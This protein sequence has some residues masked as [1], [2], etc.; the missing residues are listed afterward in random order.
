VLTP[1]PSVGPP[2]VVRI[3]LTGNPAMN[4]DMRD[5]VAPLAGWTVDQIKNLAL[6][7]SLA[8]GQI[9][10]GYGPGGTRLV[11]ENRSMPDL[12]ATLLMFSDHPE[13]VSQAGL[14]FE[15][16]LIRMAPVRF[17]YYHQGLKG[18][19]PRFL[20]L[21][22]G[23]NQTTPARLWVIRADAGPNAAPFRVGHAST[24]TFLERMQRRAGC[25]LEVEPGDQQV[26]ALIPLLE[27]QVC[28][29]LY[30][31][32]LWEGSPVQLAL[33][34]VDRADDAVI[35]PL[36]SDESDRHARGTYKVP[37]CRLG[38]HYTVG[39]GERYLTI[40]DT[41][42]QNLFTGPPLK[43]L[44]G[45]RYYLDIVISNPT[46]H[47]QTVRIIFQPRGGGAAGTFLSPRGVLEVPPIKA[48]VEYKVATVEVAAGT[49]RAFPMI[50]MPEGASNLPVR[51]IFRPVSP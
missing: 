25:I 21:V 39:E 38:F 12:P 43:G 37:D 13:K 45:V 10:K 3:T 24:R 49:S 16:G 46:R 20:K 15:G 17:Q 48:L 51:L 28:T 29:G 6:P 27:D 18:S 26:L 23:N 47:K 2:R 42:P 19:P 36:L 7:E 9:W 44:Y 11:M 34:A 50:T 31:L 5:W 22:V 35:V 4:A 30:Q 14:L 1:A 33:F 8:A 40:G 32:C 41:A